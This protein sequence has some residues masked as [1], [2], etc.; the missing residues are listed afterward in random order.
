MDDLPFTTHIPE[1]TTYLFTEAEQRVMCRVCEFAE[2]AVERLGLSWTPEELVLLREMR[3]RFEG[4]Q[5]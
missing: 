2:T 4:D 5:G 1:Y 3:A